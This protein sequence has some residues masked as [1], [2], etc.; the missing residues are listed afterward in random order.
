MYTYTIVQKKQQ[1]IF[2]KWKGQSILLSRAVSQF[3][4]IR[5]EKYWSMTSYLFNKYVY[6]GCTQKIFLLSLSTMCNIWYV[7][8]TIKKFPLLLY[9][10]S[11]R[12]FMVFTRLKNLPLVH[13]HCIEGRKKKLVLKKWFRTRMTL[14]RR[15][16]GDYVLGADEEKGRK[17]LLSCSRCSF[18]L[19]KHTLYER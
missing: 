6:F 2:F 10:R 11:G 13:T 3:Q 18:V 9:F 16:V 14:R 4:S 19:E 17:N 15:T 7:L 12:F 1:Q 8:A 5:G